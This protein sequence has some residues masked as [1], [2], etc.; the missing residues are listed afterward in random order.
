MDKKTFKKEVLSLLV[1]NAR[2]SAQE[3]ANRLGASEGEV[4]ATIAELEK[5]RVIVGYT[6][7]VSDE[8]ESD[9]VRAI[10]EVAVQPER[11]TG[12]DNV[13]ERLARFPEVRSAYLVSG[14]YDLRLEVVGNSL[15]AVASFVAGKLASQDGVK[16]CATYFLLKKYKESGVQFAREEKHERLKIVP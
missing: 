15:Q 9:E 3:I 5:E 8:A 7:I 12:F 2:I 6:A 14:K 16:S 1:R 11:D 13:A 10:I 4:L